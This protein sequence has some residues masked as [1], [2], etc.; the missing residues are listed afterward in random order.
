MKTTLAALFALAVLAL[1]ARAQTVHTA[2]RL[3]DPAP[4]VEAWRFPDLDHPVSCFAQIGEHVWLGGVNGLLMHSRDGVT[5]TRV[6]TGDTAAY[7]SLTH[8][9]SDGL[10][11]L[12]RFVP[13]VS[14]G[15]VWTFRVNPDGSP[16]EPLAF[17]NNARRDDP[18]RTVSNIERIGERFWARQISPADIY[19]SED[20][21][22][23]ER[24]NFRQI[25]P[26]PM[27]RPKRVVMADSVA[28]IMSDAGSVYASQDG[29][30]WSREIPPPHEKLFHELHA[31]VFGRRI[32]LS[33]G[34]RWGGS[35]HA[36]TG[37]TPWADADLF[38][39]RTVLG[40]AQHR[41]WALAHARETRKSGPGQ[42]DPWVWSRHA[43]FLSDDGHDW[44]EIPAPRDAN[45]R[46]D[47]TDLGFLI[48]ASGGRFY[49]VAIPDAPAGAPVIEER[50]AVAGAHAPVRLRGRAGVD[51]DAAVGL[52]RAAAGGD[53]E[54]RRALV[55]EMDDLD[56]RFH[57]NPLIM[58]AL[59]EGM[60]DDP[61]ALYR[62]VVLG[63]EAGRISG[64]EL[65]GALERAYAAGSVQAGLDLADLLLDASREPTDAGRAAEIYGRIADRT[66]FFGQRAAKGLTR[67][68]VEIAMN[69][70]DTG[71]LTDLANQIT[72]A[73]DAVAAARLLQRMAPLVG[74]AGDEARRAFVGLS[75]VGGLNLN[76]VPE[77]VRDELIRVRI[78]LGKIATD[79]EGVL[80]G[81]GAAL[82][83]DNAA[84]RELLE[85][86]GSMGHVES[87]MALGDDY[88][89]GL[90]DFPHDPVAAEMWYRKAG[91]AGD[92]RGARIAQTR[93]AL[94]RPLPNRDDPITGA[95]AEML[96]LLRELSGETGP[97]SNEDF[98]R[99]VRAAWKDGVYADAGERLGIKILADRPIR[100]EAGEGEAFTF[101]RSFRD[102][103][104]V[105]AMLPGPMVSPQAQTLFQAAEQ[106]E[107]IGPIV[108][109]LNFS[110]ADAEQGRMLLAQS[111]GRAMMGA[112]Q[113]NQPELVTNLLGAFRT[114]ANRS[115]PEASE[116][117]RQGLLGAVELIREHDASLVNDET[118]KVLNDPEAWR[119]GA[120]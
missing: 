73:G 47:A 2:E 25:S 40:M 11:V 120:P 57:R 112:K 13:N 119:D 95:D 114:L 33:F 68:R 31:A 106:A 56:G 109:V 66:D 74:D 100:V 67:A 37:D 58:L 7:R 65:A 111:L 80:D 22:A 43:F 17:A 60:G 53:N 113:Q 69:S 1:P 18:E 108:F 3:D 21:L 48:G 82:F 49:R 75:R 78:G 84:Y 94:G 51:T 70:T 45:F 4:G 79:L 39:G 90:K 93:D 102:N 104:I 101:H 42:Y 38:D 26:A 24:S 52:V 115:S 29:K 118:I 63:V 103:R 14:E 5:W 44:A 96:A 87:M 71:V 92:P 86:A 91:E 16:V 34:S 10:V 15:A 8:R 77:P 6:R 59:L 19:M 9:P 54:S 55:A 30:T 27:N 35:V 50:L 32:V 117:V 116:T 83:R 61:E 62:R 97:L 81:V 110:D 20:G 23:W 36:R 72:E 105:R 85:R 46:V 99:L 12:E 64:A 107:T 28:Y 76:S 98:A 88:L 89:G 41:G